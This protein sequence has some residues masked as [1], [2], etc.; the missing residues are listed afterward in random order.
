MSSEESVAFMRKVRQ[1][2]IHNPHTYRQFVK[3]MSEIEEKESDKLDIIKRVI[4]LFDGYPHLVRD[5]NQ[6]LPSDYQLEMQGDAVLV[7]VVDEVKGGSGMLETSSAS[8]GTL[9]GSQTNHAFTYHAFSTQ[10]GCNTTRSS[11]GGLAATGSFDNS[12]TTQFSDS[13]NSTMFRTQ[14]LGGTTG[15]Q[16]LDGATNRDATVEYIRKVKDAFTR[17]PKT[18]RRFMDALHA[19]HEEKADTLKTIKDVVSLFQH[20]TD[21]VLGF[22][23]FLPTNYRIR[24]F[25]KSGYTIQHP[26]VTEEGILDSFQINITRKSAK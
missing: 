6:F 11:G 4:L 1:T 15:T 7:K 12:S 19:Y 3:I 16:T 13:M 20:H 23:A 9:G 24:M 18:Y 14:T 26:S 8:T 17:Q 22:N 5:F 10:T 2:F 25:E 21:L